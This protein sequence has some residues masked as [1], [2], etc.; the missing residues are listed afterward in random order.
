MGNSGGNFEGFLEL[1]GVQFCAPRS[2]KSA[3]LATGPHS[4]EL[5]QP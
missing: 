5:R 2:Y 4:A 3:A 1:I